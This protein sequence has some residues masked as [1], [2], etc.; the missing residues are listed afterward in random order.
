VVG[1]AGEIAVGEDSPVDTHRPWAVASCRHRSVYEQKNP[2]AAAA[3]AILAGDGCL[4]PERCFYSTLPWLLGI[5]IPQPI[6]SPSNLE[7]AHRLSATAE[8]LRPSRYRLVRSQL[9][10]GGQPVAGAAQRPSRRIP[11]IQRSPSGGGIG[12]ACSCPRPR[13]DTPAPSLESIPAIHFQRLARCCRGPTQQD[14]RAGRTAD[15]NPQDVLTERGT[16]RTVD[17]DGRP[18]RRHVIGQRQGG[19]RRPRTVEAT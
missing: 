17:V 7:A 6:T 9:D 15:P 14:R 5:G 11:L 2:G 3:R 19:G 12:C 10:L 13:A 8:S 4:G 16:G 18:D 1:H